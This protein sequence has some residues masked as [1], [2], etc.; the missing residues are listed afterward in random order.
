MSMSPLGDIEKF[1]EKQ[2]CSS[3]QLD[4][5]LHRRLRNFELFFFGIIIIMPLLD[6]KVTDDTGVTVSL[7]ALK[8]TEI[9]GHVIE[10]PQPQ[11]VI[12]RKHMTISL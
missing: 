11:I 6:D 7:L 3:F 9:A 8:S 5:K 12:G 10:V 4:V 2:F 1:S